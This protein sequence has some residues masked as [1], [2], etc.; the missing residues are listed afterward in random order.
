[1]ENIKYPKQFM[2]QENKNGTWGFYITDILRK[3]VQ[4]GVVHLLGNFILLQIFGIGPFSKQ[5]YS[6]YKQALIL[7]I[8]TSTLF[9]K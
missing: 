1:M 6:Y 9:K 4:Q 5:R 8:S 2:V 7:T 3:F